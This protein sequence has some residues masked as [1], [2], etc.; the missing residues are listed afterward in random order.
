MKS[1]K[2]KDIHHSLHIGKN[3]SCHITSQIIDSYIYIYIYINVIMYNFIRVQ[4]SSHKGDIMF[5]GAIIG[6]NTKNGGHELYKIQKWDVQNGKDHQNL[7]MAL[8]LIT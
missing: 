8:S 2:K 3:I 6:Y 5:I 4:K 7:V 1:N